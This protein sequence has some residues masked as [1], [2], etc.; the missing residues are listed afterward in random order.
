MAERSGGTR[1]EENQAAAGSPL[2]TYPVPGWAAWRGGQRGEAVGVAVSWTSALVGAIL[3]WG[4]VWG[5][6][7]VA[8][9]YLLHVVSVAKVARRRGF[10]HWNW[11]VAVVWSGV[12]LGGAIYI[13]A[14]CVA[15]TVFHP[16]RTDDGR[17]YAVDTR[18]FD[19]EALASGEWLWVATPLWRADRVP[20]VQGIAALLGGFEPTGDGRV[21]KARR[22]RGLGTS[23]GEVVRLI[24][25]PGQ[26]V[27]WD[28]VALRVDG[29]SSWFKLPNDLTD[30]WE[31]VVPPDHWA[32]L[33]MRFPTTSERLRR[34]ASTGDENDD[35]TTSVASA[36]KF[37][38]AGGHRLVRA[39]QLWLVH[40]HH[41]QGRVW[42]RLSPFWR[43]R[44]G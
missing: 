16:V 42:G 18:R 12:V 19:P 22:F 26:R 36:A 24:A 31:F 13:P 17:R 32:V 35:L 10:P 37:Q 27:T 38:V 20:P 3:G 8:Y 2:W 30:R 33:V 6:M 41:I 28:G 23:E 14:L 11:R 15:W 21:W 7:M 25:G 29:R 40:R 4:A 39:P 1:G 9:A 34:N 5:G 43:G 44:D